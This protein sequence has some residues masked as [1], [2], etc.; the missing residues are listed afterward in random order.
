M[1]D[2]Q[3][4]G[5]SAVIAENG[6]CAT[7]HPLAAKVAIQMLEAGG[8]AMDAAIAGAILLGLCEPQSTG[9][10]GDAF[11]LFN[12]PGSDDVH[13]MNASGRAPAALQAQD[14][15]A[16]GMD[17]LPLTSPHAISLPAAMDGFIQLAKDHG[18]LG[19]KAL[20]APSIHYA[21]AGIPV[22][23]KVAFDYAQSGATLHGAGRRHYTL[24]DA[25]LEVGQMFRA[26][27]Q[28]E[29]LRRVA[30]DGRARRAQGCV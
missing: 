22:A 7:S 6:I 26:P 17:V 3:S 23:P 15:R 12:L 1:R 18:R 10:G 16:Q 9:I 4:P 13:A 11:C 30:M 27:G 14:L 8:N 25:P 5:R 19:L 28:A 2:F 24:E 20:L 29:V 21:D